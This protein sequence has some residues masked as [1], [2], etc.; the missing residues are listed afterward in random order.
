MEEADVTL[1]AE[2]YPAGDISQVSQDI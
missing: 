2:Q 1:Y